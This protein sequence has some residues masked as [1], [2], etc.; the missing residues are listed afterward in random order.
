MRQEG[1]GKAFHTERLLTEAFVCLEK[2][3]F[4]KAGAGSVARHGRRVLFFLIYIFFP[5]DF[6]V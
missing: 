2:L 4:P 6:I 5:G 3:A 1:H